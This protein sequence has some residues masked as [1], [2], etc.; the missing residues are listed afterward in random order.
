MQLSVTIVLYC[1]WLYDQPISLLLTIHYQKLSSMLK[2][3]QAKKNKMSM[4]TGN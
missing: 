3:L 1:T 4:A 2:S